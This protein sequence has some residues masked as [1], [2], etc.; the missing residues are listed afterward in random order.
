VTATSGGV[1]S[2]ASISISSSSTAPPPSFAGWANAPSTYPLIS[3]NPFNA[4]DALGWRTAWNDAGLLT[5]SADPAAPVSSAS[6][7]QFSYPIGFVGAKGPANEYLDFAGAT[8]FYSGVS[9]KANANWQGNSTNVNKIEFVL[10]GGGMGGA[11]LCLYGPN[12]GPYQMQVALE[13]ANGDTRD[14]LYPNMA[15]VPVVMGQFHQIEWQLQ[16]NTTTNPANGIVKWWLDGRLIGQ[17]TDV[18]FP[19]TSI[20]EYQLSPTWGG[21]PD[22]KTQNDFFWIDHAIVKGF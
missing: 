9:W 19:S 21:A 16:Y 2:S 6:V 10:M 18:Q 8:H 12:G 1:S 13:F 4:L 17:F 3:D 11:Y 5:V 20:V 14:M 15:N 7:L 22:V